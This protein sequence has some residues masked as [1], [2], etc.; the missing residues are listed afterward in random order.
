MPVYTIGKVEAAGW[1][2]QVWAQEVLAFLRSNITLAKL[3]TRDYSQNVASYGD[4]VNVPKPMTLQAQD[5]P[6][7]GSQAVVLDRVQVQLNRFKTV[8]IVIGD[9]AMYQTRADLLQTVSRAAGIALA[10]AIESDLFA[11]YTGAGASVGTAGAN[12]TTDTITLARRK[13]V[14]NKLPA[15]ATKNLVLSPKDYAALLNLPNVAQVY[16]FGGP[17]GIRAG[18]VPQL[19]GFDVYESQLTPVVAGTPPTTYKLAFGEGALGLVTRVLPAPAAT[20]AS[21]VVTDD[22]SGLSFRMTLGYDQANKQHRLDL[23]I[24]YGV[25]VLR[26]EWLVQVKA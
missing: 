2:P 3:A 18:R 1:I 23:D 25:A 20:V 12:I 8:P 9:L 14:E 22:E 6:A 10:E 19:F 24:L 5:V 7:S 15:M 16:Q 21:A 4:T 11:L 17:E 26:P 13:L